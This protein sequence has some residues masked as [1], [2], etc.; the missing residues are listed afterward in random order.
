MPQ[1]HGGKPPPAEYPYRGPPVKLLRVDGRVNRDR[2]ENGEGETR[3]EREWVPVFVRGQEGR[4]TH[5]D[6]VV[7]VLGLLM[8]LVTFVGGLCQISPV[9]QVPTVELDTQGK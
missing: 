4:R 9:Q 1:H 8:L 6:W 3:V 2:E 7:M 5:L